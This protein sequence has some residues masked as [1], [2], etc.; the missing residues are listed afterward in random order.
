MAALA[1]DDAALH[2]VI[3]QRDHRHGGLRHVVGGAALDGIDHIL[4][5]H[6]VAVVELH[7]VPQGKG[8]RQT[9][10]RN[11]VVAGNG[12]GKVSLG[13]G[14]HQPFKYIEHDLAGSC[15][16]RFV[17][18]KTVVQVLGDANHNGVGGR[19]A[20]RR[21][22]CAAVSASAEYGAQESRQKKERQASLLH[23]FSFFH[24]CRMGSVWGGNCPPQAKYGSFFLRKRALRHQSLFF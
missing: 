14:L 7:P 16:H 24:H 10:F 21:L 4:R 15:L 18:V 3:G 12:R 2:F 8:I 22:G 9:V 23:S 1:A 17:R 5:R 13:G 20:L 11:L 6:R 19:S